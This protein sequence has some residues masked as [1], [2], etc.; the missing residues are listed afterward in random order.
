MLA[1]FLAIRLS[2]SGY[3]AVRISS[4]RLI[5]PGSISAVFPMSSANESSK[6]L[7]TFSQ[8]LEGI[9]RPPH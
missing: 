6:F 2:S 9:V 8:P 1:S 3:F 7:T 4:K 5:M